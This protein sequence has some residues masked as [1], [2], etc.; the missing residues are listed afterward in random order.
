[1]NTDRIAGQWKQLNGK[2]KQQ[3]GKLTDDDL[4]RAEG[5][6]EYLAG[7]SRSATASP[8]ISPTSRFG[9]S[10]KHCSAVRPASRRAYFATLSA[11]GRVICNS[12]NTGLVAFIKGSPAHAKGDEKMKGQLL[13]IFSAAA[14]LNLAGC[15]QAPDQAQVQKDVEKAQAEGQKKVADARANLE[16]VVAENRKDIVETRVDNSSPATT[17]GTTPSTTAEPG[18][19]ANNAANATQNVAEAQQKAA[20]K[21][22]DAQYNVDKAS[23][24]AK[25]DVAVA[26]CKGQTGDAAK[27]CKDSAKSTYDSEINQ[28]KAKNNSAHQNQRG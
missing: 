5:S 17:T 2:I 10:R 13:V 18:S 27:S 6:S 16:K 19:P 23:A 14:A 20:K 24:E 3:W 4:K 28:A 9:S 15:T 21:T 8:A 11:R 26:R 1:M 22:A 7:K 25:F 12:E